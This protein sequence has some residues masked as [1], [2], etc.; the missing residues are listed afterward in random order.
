MS[1]PALALGGLALSA[2]GQVGSG[3]AQSQAASYQ[4]AVSRN[5]AI[6]AGQ[7]A[8]Y[9]EE[10]GA[11]QE[12]IAGRKAAAQS[13]AV[14]AGLAANNIDVNSGSAVGVETGERESGELSEENVINNAMLQAYG[15][16]TQVT[17]Y[18]AQ[19]GLQSQE[20][21]TAIPGSLLAAGG[22]FASN[23][24]LLPG[25]FSGFGSYEPFIDSGTWG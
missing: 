24:S 8:T 2:V 1:L 5:N 17:G 3:I 20:A 7:N 4:A 11:Q 25:K 13:G 22:S 10:A 18:Q 15:Y 16:Q 12:E 9:A 19:A 21:A 14:K 23:A 6:E